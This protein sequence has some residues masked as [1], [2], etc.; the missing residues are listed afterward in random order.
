M[1]HYSVPIQPKKGNFLVKIEHFTEKRKILIQ[2]QPTKNNTF[3]R[4]IEHLMWVQFPP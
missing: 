3:L 1:E 4:K 2:V